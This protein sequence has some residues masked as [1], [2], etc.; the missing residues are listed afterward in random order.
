[1]KTISFEKLRAEFVD[2][3]F[4]L[5]EDDGD[6]CSVFAVD[7]C[8]EFDLLTVKKAWVQ[9]GKARQF[10]NRIDN[11]YRND[12][13]KSIRRLSALITQSYNRI[14]EEMEIFA[15]PKP[16]EETYDFIL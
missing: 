13:K 11:L 9:L 14:A 4:L 12:Q 2:A 7:F 1:M 3:S 16:K 10:I 5:D 8:Y 15:D 6:I